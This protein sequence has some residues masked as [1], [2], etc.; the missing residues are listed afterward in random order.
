MVLA[1]QALILL[2]LAWGEF[3][4]A[5]WVVLGGLAA[6]YGVMDVVLLLVAAKSSVLSNLAV[7][8]GFYML[9]L[10][11]CIAYGVIL[12]MLRSH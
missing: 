3:P 1:I 6:C 2:G 5:T 9:Q 12:D 10:L 7:R 11:V 4:S 8:L